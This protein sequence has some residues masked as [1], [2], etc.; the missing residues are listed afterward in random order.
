MSL[1]F[2][3]HFF[4]SLHFLRTLLVSHGAFAPILLLTLVAVVP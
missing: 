2:L 1:I 4:A 3:Q